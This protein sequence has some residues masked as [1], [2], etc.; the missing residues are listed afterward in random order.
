[1]GQDQGIEHGVKSIEHPAQGGGKKS[2]ALRR[3]DL[4]QRGRN[5]G[6]HSQG[7]SIAIAGLAIK[8]PSRG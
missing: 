8:N 7:L 5:A 3:S 4:R 2:S 1:M 6:N